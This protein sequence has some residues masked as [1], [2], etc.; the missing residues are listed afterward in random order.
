MRQGEP[1]TIHFDWS[2]AEAR[3][4]FALALAWQEVILLGFGPVCYISY[5]GV[6]LK[7]CGLVL[8]FA[9]LALA[10]MMLGFVQSGNSAFC[11]YASSMGWVL[12]VVSIRLACPTGSKIPL[13]ALKQALVL[14]GANFLATKVIPVT[15]VRISG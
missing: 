14:M 2:T 10:I 3:A 4:A 1:F 6:S 8:G 13:Q 7:I 11:F 5:L 12:L 9:V 15:T